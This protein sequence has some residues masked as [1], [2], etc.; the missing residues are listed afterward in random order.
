MKNCYI[1]I[2]HPNT[3]EKFKLLLDNLKLL[4]KYTNCC[5]ILSVNYFPHGIENWKGELY[6]YIIY[7]DCNEIQRQLLTDTKYTINT[8]HWDWVTVGVEPE[9]EEDGVSICIGRAVNNL[10]LRGAQLAKS[11]GYNGFIFM[12]YDVKVLGGKIL[13]KLESSQNLFFDSNDNSNAGDLQFNTYCFK[14]DE[15]MLK[16]IEHCSI[17]DNWN[18]LKYNHDKIGYLE[19]IYYR[20]LFKKYGENIYN[21]IQT[22]KVSE[23]KNLGYDINFDMNFKAYRCA[24]CPDSGIVI[25]LLEFIHSSADREISLEFEGK[26]HIFGNMKGRWV[27][28][29][30][31]KWYKG[32]EYTTTVNGR[33]FTREIKK[34]DLDRNIL[35]Y[36]NKDYNNSIRNNK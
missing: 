25:L 8:N 33:K 34:H 29:I 26:N 35:T 3:P 30:L 6:D 1:V 31:T 27:T 23:L 18:N 2:G 20:Y 13:K 14:S 5:I 9:M 28:H 15:N 19:T 32:M 16:M 21:Y 17:E 12:N 7:S 24:E 22:I 36:K 10:Q 4:R 11:L